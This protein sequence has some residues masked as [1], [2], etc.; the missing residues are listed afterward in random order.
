MSFPD[1]CL[2]PGSKAQHRNFV[3]RRFPYRAFVHHPFASRSSK[4]VGVPVSRQRE[5]GNTCGHSVAGGVASHSIG[6]LRHACC[7]EVYEKEVQAARHSPSAAAG[8]CRSLRPHAFGGA[9]CFRAEHAGQLACIGMALAGY[10]LQCWG[11]P[12]SP[13]VV[14]LCCCLS[15]YISR[16][17]FAQLASLFLSIKTNL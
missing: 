3:P 14:R 9:G 12:H 4:G 8:D 1:R 15:S 7:A 16:P 2:L 11:F 5:K 17:V 13:Y 10:E 6:A